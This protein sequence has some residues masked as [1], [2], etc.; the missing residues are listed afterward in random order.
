MT[1]DPC[2]WETFDELITGGYFPDQ[3]LVASEDSHT[4]EL[5][6]TLLVTGTIMWD[7]K[8]PGISFDSMGRQMLFQYSTMA[9]NNQLFHAFGRARMLLWTTNDD[10]KKI[11]PRSSMHS[12]KT[13]FYMQKTADVKEIVG[14]AHTDRSVQVKVGREPRYELESIGLALKRGNEKGMELPSR[15]RENV[16]DFADDFMKMLNSVGKV[17]STEIVQ[18]LKKQELSGKSTIGILPTNVLSTWHEEVELGIDPTKHK[19][20]DSRLIK[21]NPELGKRI[22]SY[23]LRRA[24]LKQFDKLRVERDE[25]V[26]LAEE[27]YNLE[28][29]IL[30]LDDGQEKDAQLQRLEQMQKDFDSRLERTDKNYRTNILTDVDDRLSLSSPVPRLMWDA[31]PFEPLV[32]HPEE[33][34]P[35]TRVSLSDITPRPLP[36]DQSAETF[37]YVRDFTHGL[38]F[39]MTDPVPKALENMQPGA[40]ELVD[41]VPALRDPKKGGRLNLNNMRVRML[42][43]E[44]VDGLTQAFRDWPFRTPDA[45]HSKYFQLRVGGSRNITEI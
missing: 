1:G 9:W 17:D 41:Q 12:G 37:D 32:M 44:M 5:N 10:F 19:R 16:H 18:Y 13:S 40:A 8:L 6:E 20:T 42:T 24:N 25:A 45:D 21:S 35:P 34:W 27:I 43:V 31:R 38:F 23:R 7:P 22:K 28:C 39:N 11:L 33:V 2:R 4:P 14:P 15:R 36:S 26:D 29:R 3:K 30:G